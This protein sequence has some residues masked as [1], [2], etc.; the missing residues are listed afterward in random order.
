LFLGTPNPSFNNGSGT[1][2]TSG[3]QTTLVSSPGYAR[4]SH[5]EAV[6]SIAGPTDTKIYQIQTAD[7]PPN[8]QPLVLTVTV[9]ALGVNGTAPRVTVI[10]GSGNT[11]V[12]VQVLANGNGIFTVQA[13]GIKGG[14]L[15][16]LEIGSGVASGSP[17]SGNFALTAQFGT[18]AA[19]LGTLAAATNVA[20]GATLANTL[21]IAE[22]QLMSFL[23]SAN[24][25]G[26]TAAPGSAI[27]MTVRDQLG[28][29]VYTLTAAAGDT[30]SSAALL[31]TPGAYTITYTALGQA[32]AG[33][34][35]LAFQLQGESISD[36]IGPTL[37]DPTLAPD[38]TDP[39][40]PGSFLY[41]DDTVTTADYDS[42]PAVPV[43]DTTNPDVTSDPT[44]VACC[45]PSATCGPG[46]ASSTCDPAIATCGPG[47]ASST[48]GPPVV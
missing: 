9:R 8:N 17:A 38:Y 23:L 35:P 18:A 7:A 39:D 36:P 37:T 32:G 27:A 24:A 40:A 41:P 5:Y 30:V 14:G 1:S 4:N 42:T 29:V 19:N 48:C 16:F 43:D 12:P 46:P 47:P 31:L 34:L 13:V 15:Y 2:N 45:P 44:A 26:G 22:P 3:G 21:Y 28:R 11:P 25:V 6:G 20:P 33:A 10:N